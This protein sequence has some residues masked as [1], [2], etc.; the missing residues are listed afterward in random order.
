MKNYRKAIHEY[1]FMHKLIR[2]A[3]KRNRNGRTYWK[4]IATRKITQDISYVIRC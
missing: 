4:S 3:S 2:V 1:F